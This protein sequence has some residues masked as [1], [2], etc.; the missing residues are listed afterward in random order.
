MSFTSFIC[1]KC[2]ADLTQAN[3]VARTYI[4]K[5]STDEENG[6]DDK[7]SYGHYGDDGY[8]TPD[9]EADLSDGRYDL[10]SD[11]DSCTSCDSTL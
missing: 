11:S 4:N 2:R 1:P 6:F 8:F 9:Q 7:I 5:D 3:S 10:M